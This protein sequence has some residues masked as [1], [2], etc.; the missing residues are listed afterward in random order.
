MNWLK[1]VLKE[2][3]KDSYERYRDRVEEYLAS[4]SSMV[5]LENR[6]RQIERGE[7]KL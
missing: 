3:S 4:S 6:I 1:A 7:V 5:E 2:L